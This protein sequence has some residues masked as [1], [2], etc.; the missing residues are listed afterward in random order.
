ME[1]LSGAQKNIDIVEVLLS[2][3]LHYDVMSSNMF[4]GNDIINQPE[5]H[6]LVQELEKNFNFDELTYPKASYLLTS[7]RVH[8]M[9]IV[10]HMPA[11][12]M[13]LLSHIFDASLHKIRKTCEYKKIDLIFDSYIDK[14]VKEEER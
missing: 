12:E 3:I 8:F 6:I 4:V 13:N 9:S 14:S 5:K 11:S 10:H 7:L 2:D 1:K